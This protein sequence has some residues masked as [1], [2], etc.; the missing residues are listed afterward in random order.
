[1]VSERDTCIG[2]YTAG[3]THLL[4][5]I[6]ADNQTIGVYHHIAGHFDFGSGFSVFS[7]EGF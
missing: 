4:R 5:H 7:M 1:M 2:V 3:H 6:M